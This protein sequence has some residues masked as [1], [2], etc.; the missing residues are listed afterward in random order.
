MQPTYIK[1]EK[2]LKDKLGYTQKE[3]DEFNKFD[4]YQIIRLYNSIRGIAKNVHNT[5]RFDQ[6]WAMN[7]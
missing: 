5:A 3:I 7:P 4:P 2:F 6:Y 1:A